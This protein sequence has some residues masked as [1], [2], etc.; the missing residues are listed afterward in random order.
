M[1]DLQKIP[2]IGKSIEQD[3]FHI[4][5]HCIEDLK[6]QDPKLM[7]LQSCDVKGYQEDRCLLYVYRL[8]V[9]YANNKQHDSEK[10]K[11]WYWKDKW[12]DAN[13]LFC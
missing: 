3:L 13:H 12:D 9:Y 2:G 8:A 7:F 5:I 1:S 11:W 10:L 6:D 4:G